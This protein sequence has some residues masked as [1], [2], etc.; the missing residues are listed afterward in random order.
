[1]GSVDIDNIDNRYLT[2]AVMIEKDITREGQN[3]VQWSEVQQ[4]VAALLH[5]TS[6]GPKLKIAQN[7][8]PVKYWSLVQCSG[9]R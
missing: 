6:R 8:A 3:I 1:M 2:Q 4:P 5:I 9:I 7:A